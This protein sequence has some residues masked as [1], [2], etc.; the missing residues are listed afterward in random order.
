MAGLHREVF[1]ESR[2]DVH[3]Q[4]LRCD[5]DLRLADCT[6]VL[7][8]TG[9]VAF[10]T[11]SRGWSLRTWVETIK[12]RRIGRAQTSPVP[13]AF[14]VAYTFTGH[15]V[16]HSFEV[17]KVSAWS[18]EHPN[19]YR[20]VAELI[21]PDGSVTETHS[22]L[23]GFR[24]VEV[25]ERQLLVNGQPIWIFGVNRHDHHPVRGKAVTVEDMRDDLVLMKQHNITAVRTAH[26]PNDP[27]LLDL[28]D[29]LGLVRR[30]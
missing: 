29:E 9:T 13:W 18:A 23:I 3:L 4:N 17:P 24:H 15:Q 12:G 21:A 11:P 30:R 27:R 28:C 16:C 26:Y 8:V 25:R 5:A 22:Q 10:H 7:S 19:R 6:G 14:A 20:V 2:A 1:V